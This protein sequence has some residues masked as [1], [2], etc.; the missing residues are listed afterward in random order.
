MFLL[1]SSF[2]YALFVAAKKSESESKK[3]TKQS[4]QDTRILSYGARPIVN[5]DVV[6][7]ASDVDFQPLPVEYDV[8]S[9][10]NLFNERMY[11]KTFSAERLRWPL[12]VC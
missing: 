3:S 7:W 6:D 10:D 11:R 4:M 9:I 5:N 1:V 12:S 2:V 8:V